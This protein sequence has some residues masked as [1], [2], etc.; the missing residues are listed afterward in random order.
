LFQSPSLRGV[1]RDASA[2]LK[3]GQRFWFQSPSL[4][5]VARD[6]SR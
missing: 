1:A 6:R 3:G 4:R 2:I 5:G